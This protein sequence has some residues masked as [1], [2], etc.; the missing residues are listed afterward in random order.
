[1]G[2]GGGADVDTYLVAVERR[3]KE[4]RY[5]YEMDC[6]RYPIYLHYYK[7]RNCKASHV[8]GWWVSPRDGHI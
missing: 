1:M 4:L 7:G 5:I 8:Y 2:R 6:G 3:G